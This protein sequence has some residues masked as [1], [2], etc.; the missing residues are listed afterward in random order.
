MAM[1]I[2]IFSLYATKRP[3]ND[4]LNYTDRSAFA[5]GE[6]IKTVSNNVKVRENGER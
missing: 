3:R 5:T 4:T 2:P 6:M 1:K